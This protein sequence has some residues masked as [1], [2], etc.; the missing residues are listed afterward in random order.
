[1]DKEFKAMLKPKKKENVATSQA[2]SPQ[3]LIAFDE[4]CLQASHEGIGKKSPSAS[5]NSWA[6]LPRVVSGGKRNA[7]RIKV[8]DKM[9]PAM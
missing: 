4:S 3:I 7:V 8:T 9:E 1:M 2:D 5:I 6:L